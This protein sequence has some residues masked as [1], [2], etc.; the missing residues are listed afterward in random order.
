V[1][2]GFVLLAAFV[3]LN[4]FL[5]YRH[6]SRV[7]ENGKAVADAYERRAAAARVLTVMRDAETGQRGYL[8]TG[9]EPYLAPFEQAKKDLVTNLD[10]LGQVKSLGPEEDKLVASLRSAVDVKMK[11]LEYSIALRRSQGFDA[12]LAVML[13][14][15]GLESMDAIRSAAAAIRELESRELDR[16][17]EQSQRSYY[18]T[19]VAR[20]LATLLGLGLIYLSY[21]MSDRQVAERA[22]NAEL[23]HEQAERFRVTLDSIG[24]AVVVTDAA[25][26][27]RFMNPVAQT[28]TGWRDGWEG[29]PISEV[30]NIQDEASGA[31]G[32][33]PV[34]RVLRERQIV[35]LE[36]HTV[37][38]RRDGNRVPIDDSAAPIFGVDGVLTGVVLVFRDIT[39]R[40]KAELLADSQKQALEE[41]DRRKDEFLAVLAHELRNPLGALR[42]ATEVLRLVPSDSAEGGKARSILERQ[43][44]LMGRMVDDLIDVARI[45]SGRMVLRRATTEIKD[46]VEAAVET[47]ASLFEERRHQLQVR[48]PK[49]PVF[50]DGDSVRLAQILTNLLSNAARYTDPGGRIE[51]EVS[52]LGADARVVVRDNG[53][54]I[55]PTLL[56]HVFDLFRQGHHTT[57]TSQGGLG[58]G[59]TLA[60]RIVEMHGGTIQAASAGPGQGSTFT[61][62]LPACAAPVVGAD[63]ATNRVTSPHRVLIVEDNPDARESLETMLRLSG[64][65]VASAAD[66]KAGL[67]KAREF[68][69]TVALVDLGLPDM[70]GLEVARGLRADPS[71]VGA[72]LVAVTGW[73]QDEDRQ[74]SVDAGFEHHLV[75]PVEPDKLFALLASLPARF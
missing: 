16:R 60:R 10:A 1:I 56:P 38:V 30:F 28:L 70:S 24:D 22:R 59:L 33:D 48:L 32:R 8:L 23:R 21:R 51:L 47:T 25:A 35:A 63:V 65:Q 58:V 43:V 19:V 2:L 73:A 61:M 64:H 6:T 68:R 34:A 67:Q 18:S 52:R 50:I 49:E 26:V 46:A 42:N 55:A 69:P 45:S 27:V 72:S 4:G 62:T 17:N 3:L 41:S 15:Q 66:G 20:V 36:N 71:L 37:L 29:R 5:A 74:R 14:N 57:G 11:E 40:R 31:P 12:A 75:K 7:Y 39:A 13:T 9:A 53:T 44:R 54:G